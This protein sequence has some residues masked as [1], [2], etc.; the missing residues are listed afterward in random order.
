MKRLLIVLVSA[1]MLLG[2][3]ACGNP[4][5]AL[6]PADIANECISND[7]TEKT[8]GEIMTALCG[9]Y[10]T[11][12]KEGGDGYT[13]VTFA[14]NA[15][16]DL[17][18]EAESMVE[19]RFRC[20]IFDDES[21]SCELVKATYDSESADNTEGA[22][23]LYNRMCMDVSEEQETE[24]AEETVEESAPA[25][26]SVPAPSEE[27][28]SSASESE[29]EG[30]HA[31]GELS[32]IY[33]MDGTYQDGSELWEVGGN[34]TFNVDGSCELQLYTDAT[35]YL[36]RGSYTESEYFAQ[37]IEYT[38]DLR[39]SVTDTVLETFERSISGR[40]VATISKFGEITLFF[41]DPDWE[42]ELVFE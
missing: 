10:K 3:T 6:D 5:A 29:T 27:N 25:P 22:A 30:F 8:V 36:L 23:E 14:G 21:F 37:A 39:G 18:A 7:Y 15:I 19:L 31:Y 16:E 34:I 35:E 33:W 24:D 41:T 1:V 20:T 26:E 11:A 32:G 17:Y 9:K 12:S 42:C 4:T 2:M 28:S 13:Y 38:V 40:Y